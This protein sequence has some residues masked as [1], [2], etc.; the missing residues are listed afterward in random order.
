M[1]PKTMHILGTDYTVAEVEN[2]C[3]ANG[4]AYYG[5]IVHTTPL[6]QI[7][8]TLAD[9]VK[10]QSLL[11]ESLHGLLHQAGHIDIEDEERVTWFLGCQ[12]PHFVRANR[13]LFLEILKGADNG[14]S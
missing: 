8:S 12:L 2:L 4:N 14:D 13:D 11:H 3:G 1:L 10:L 5:R 7:E 6:I 9:S